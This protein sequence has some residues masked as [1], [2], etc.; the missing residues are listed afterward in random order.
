[1]ND[2]YPPHDHRWHLAQVKKDFE[3][4]DPLQQLYKMVEYAYLICNC[5]E[6]NKK[7]VKLK[8]QA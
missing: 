2:V 3:L 7:P 8:E 1:M 5:G 6:L 4:V